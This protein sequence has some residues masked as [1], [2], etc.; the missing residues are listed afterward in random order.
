M[1]RFNS[2]LAAQIAVGT[3][4]QEAALM[5]SGAVSE[6]DGVYS[7]QRTCNSGPK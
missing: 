2:K 1:H 3:G 6:D 5:K 4:F 7:G